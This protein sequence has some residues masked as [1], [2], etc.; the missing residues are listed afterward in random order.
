VIIVSYQDRRG[1]SCMRA[2]DDKISTVAF[3]ARLRCEATITHGGE[4][5]GEV[6]YLQN[7]PDKRRKWGWWI[8]PDG[9]PTSPRLSRRR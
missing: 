2:F 3:I 7:A 8:D 4:K 1:A 9:L 6:Y 5:I